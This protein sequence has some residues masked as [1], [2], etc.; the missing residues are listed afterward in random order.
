MLSNSIIEVIQHM[1]RQKCKPEDII[2][3]LAR[4]AKQQENG[5]NIDKLCP[6]AAAQPHVENSK[7][8]GKACACHVTVHKPY[9]LTEKIAN[10]TQFL[11][12]KGCGLI[13]VIPWNLTKREKTPIE[14]HS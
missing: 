14:A 6:L 12:Y 7:C 2:T 9:M 10:P 3:E 13:R 8:L 5:E 1:T 4:L 11:L